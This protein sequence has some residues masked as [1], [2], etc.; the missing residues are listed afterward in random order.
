M[1]LQDFL[2]SYLSESLGGATIAIVE[3]NFIDRDDD[4]IDYVPSIFK[5]V[6]YPNILR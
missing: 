1:P 5:V 4:W 3:F 6:K 2:R